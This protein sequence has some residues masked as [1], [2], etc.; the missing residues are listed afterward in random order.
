MRSDSNV[1]VSLDDGDD[2]RSSHT[3]MLNRIGSSARA[4]AGNVGRLR[5]VLLGPL[6]A[7]L[8]SFRPIVS[9]GYV[10]GQPSALYSDDGAIT[11]DDDMTLPA[12]LWLPLQRAAAIGAKKRR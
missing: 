3:L 7:D 12:P 8:K 10:A 9:A 2:S 1:S 5:W 4:R 6:A 11:V